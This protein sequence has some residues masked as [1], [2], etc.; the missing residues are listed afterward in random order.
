MSERS[1]SENRKLWEAAEKAAEK[2][3]AE[4]KEKSAEEKRKQK[5]RVVKLCLLMML[6]AFVI[7]FAGIAWFAMNRETS[8]GGM[9]IKS[10]AN[11]FE[12]KVS[13]NTIGFNDLYKHLD[14]NLTG[15]SGTITTTGEGGQVISWRM[16]DGD[17]AVRPGSQG[18]LEFEVISDRTDL[19]G[20]KYSL[21]ITS[22]E[23]E[24]HVETTSDGLGGK[25]STE[26][27]D[28]LH[29]IESPAY[30]GAALNAASY[31]NGHVLFFTGRTGNSKDNYKYYGFIND[32]EDF[33]LALNN[34]S[35]II[36]WIWPNTLGQI[37]L[38]ST[39]VGYISGTPVLDSAASTYSTDRINLTAYLKSNS[40]SIFSGNENYSNLIDTKKKKKDGALSYKTEFD[41]LSEGYN[42]ADQT[43]GNYVDYTLIHMIVN[44]Y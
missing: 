16:A 41:K 6:I 14:S 26:V 40:V 43:I 31:F 29:V 18:E 36:Y 32:K 24:T 15:N 37:T 2:A 38:D 5:K 23:A 25:I 9:S 34:G 17:D 33:Q 10:K 8:T 7:V 1:V 21:M 28:N 30:S 44:G 13:G 19:S 4:A 3:V 22:F 42:A 35:G 20:L 12:L 39:D 27:V 11:G